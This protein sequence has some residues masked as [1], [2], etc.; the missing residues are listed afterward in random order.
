MFAY[1]WGTVENRTWDTQHSYLTCL[2]D[3][4]VPVNPHTEIC[5]TADRIKS[6]FRSIS[7]MRG[8]LDYDIDGVVYKVNSVAY[9]MQIGALS[10]APK[11]AVAHKFE[12]ERAATVIKKIDI[13]VGRTG[14]LTPVGR[15]QPINV[16]GVIVSNVTLHN[17]SEIKRKDIR[18]GDTVII[19]RAGDVIP[20]IITVVKEKRPNDTEPFSYP[21]QCPECQS[22]AICEEDEVV[23]RCTGGLTCPACLLYTSDA[24]DE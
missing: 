16:G 3:W 6:L 21:E 24:A 5:L 10:K 8:T 2:K 7:D 14:A 17:E 22:K 12:A 9:Q 13:Q 11:W 15:L 1:A 19:Q 20:Q 4:G 23:R 18:E